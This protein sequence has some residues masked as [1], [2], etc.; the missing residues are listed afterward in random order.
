[1][2]GGNEQALNVLD[3]LVGQET[4]AKSKPAKAQ[5]AASTAQSASK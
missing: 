1:M 2:A 5:E 4:K 3:H